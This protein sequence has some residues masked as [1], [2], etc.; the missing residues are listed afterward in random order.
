MGLLS[1]T[2]MVVMD[3]RSM[4]EAD[5]DKLSI[6]TFIVGGTYIF[7]LVSVSLVRPSML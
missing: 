3:D 6:Y 5:K 7:S 2:L 1:A 4:M